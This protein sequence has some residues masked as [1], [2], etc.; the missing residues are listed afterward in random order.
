M[1]APT[2]RGF[3]STSLSRNRTRDVSAF[4]QPA[5]RA[6]AAPATGA[7]RCRARNGRRPIAPG[8]VTPGWFD[9]RDLP[10]KLPFPSSMTAM[11][12]L[13]IGTFEGFWALEME[14]RGAEEVIAI[15]ILD[16]LAWDW[17]AGSNDAVVEALEDR[18]R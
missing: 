2:S 6:H 3:A 8:I 14:R 18:K 13:D 7:R 17:P 5:S 4:L 15:D 1:C 9:L 12:C 11:R 10:P 16:P